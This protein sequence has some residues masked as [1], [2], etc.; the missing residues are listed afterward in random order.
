MIRRILR[1]EF[2]T[3]CDVYAQ[4]KG[5]RLEVYAEVMHVRGALKVSEKDELKNRNLIVRKIVDRISKSM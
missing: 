3:D 5:D 1:N 4:I 2:V